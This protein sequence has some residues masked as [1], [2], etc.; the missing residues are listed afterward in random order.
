MPEAQPDIEVEVISETKDSEES[1]KAQIIHPVFEDAAQMFDHALDAAEK[2]TE[3]AREVGIPAEVPEA[4]RETLETA[5]EGLREAGV[6]AHEAQV[7]GGKAMEF[8]QKMGEKLTEI[9]GGRG[10]FARRVN[11]F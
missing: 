2:A 6:K 10:A 8:A 7:A 11:L 9:R 4:V 3:A 5:A 1:S